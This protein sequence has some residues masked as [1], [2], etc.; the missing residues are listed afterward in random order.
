MLKKF[1]QQTGWTGK[2]PSKKQ[3]KIGK[4]KAGEN[5]T[6]KQAPDT[7]KIKTNKLNKQAKCTQ[8]TTHNQKTTFFKI[9]YSFYQTEQSSSKTPP[10]QEELFWA[11]LLLSLTCISTENLRDKE[12][13]W[14]VQEINSII[15][16]D[17]KLNV[18]FY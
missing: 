17:F 6:N 14:N 11:E 12:V 15:Y 8:N 3:R 5:Q 9:S 10:C 4:G 16:K 2:G 1:R 13:V 18:L 7:I